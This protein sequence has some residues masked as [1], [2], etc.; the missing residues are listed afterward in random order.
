MER[1]Q[2]VIGDVDP[3]VVVSKLQKLWHKEILTIGPAKETRK[4]KKEPKNDDE[5]KQIA[6]KPCMTKYYYVHS[7]EE[8]PNACVIC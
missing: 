3:V 8:N 6:Y 4:K 1:K 5:E 2:T 7:D